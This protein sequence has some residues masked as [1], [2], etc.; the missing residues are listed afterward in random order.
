M[1][2]GNYNQTGG[3]PGFPFTNISAESGVDTAGGIDDDLADA[4]V[5]LKGQ[6]AHV[7]FLDSTQVAQ[8]LGAQQAPVGRH[9]E[10]VPRQ[11]H[12]GEDRKLRHAGLESAD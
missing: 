10:V 8:D 5:N 6:A 7:L 4:L 1:V 9:Q 11:V 2:D 3:S 12:R